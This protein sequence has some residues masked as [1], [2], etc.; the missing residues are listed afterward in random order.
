MHIFYYIMNG[1][2]NQN[3]SKTSV[4]KK[5]FA[6][7]NQVEITLVEQPNYIK[8]TR[9]QGNPGAQGET[10]VMGPPGPPGFPGD[11]GYPGPQVWISQ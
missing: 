2:S 4:V 11:R 8:C 1:I 9:L 5:R 10:G 3:N 6:Q 7:Y